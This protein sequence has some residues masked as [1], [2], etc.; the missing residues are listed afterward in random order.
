M[1]TKETEN[2]SP[3]AIDSFPSGVLESRL[4]SPS[5]EI[6]SIPDHIVVGNMGYGVVDGETACHCSLKVEPLEL[7]NIAKD[8][9]LKIERRG[10]L[11]SLGT[12]TVM[13]NAEISRLVVNIQ[14]DG[15]GNLNF[16]MCRTFKL[17]QSDDKTRSLCLQVHDLWSSIMIVM[18]I[19]ANGSLIGGSRNST[20]HE[21]RAIKHVQVGLYI[22]TGYCAKLFNGY[23]LK[24]HTSQTLIIMDLAPMGN[25]DNKVSQ[26]ISV[27]MD[28]ECSQVQATHRKEDRSWLGLTMSRDF[29]A[30][31]ITVQLRDV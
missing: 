12:I 7:Q 29:V 25:T 13:A 1:V 31:V 8:L 21:F 27:R 15:R 22:V 14:N 28:I 23:R 10:V 4:G 5:V 24:L 16:R 19:R 11:N 9:G 3:A 20:I 17:L 26:A 6:H 18:W 30:H 2:E